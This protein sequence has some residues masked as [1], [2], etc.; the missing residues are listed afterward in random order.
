MGRCDGDRTVL[1]L[2]P[3]LQK[4]GNGD[5]VVIK[6]GLL[7]HGK[8]KYWVDTPEKRVSN[9]ILYYSSVILV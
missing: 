4:R 2:G 8:N 9:I 1:A 7:R 6:P 5:V 3:G